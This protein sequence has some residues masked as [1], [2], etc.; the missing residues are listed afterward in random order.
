MS[1]DD[2]GPEAVP[3]LLDMS[4]FP[5]LADRLQQGFLDFI[6]L[7]RLMGNPDGLTDDPAFEFGGD[8]ALATDKGALL[9]RQ[10]PGRD[11]RRRP[12]RGRAR[13]HPHGA[14]RARDELLDAAHPQHRLR[15]LRADP[16]PAL[17]GRGGAAA[18]ALADPVDVGPG[19]A[20]RL[21]QPHDH[22][23]AAEHARAQG[24]DRDGLRRSP[25]RQRPDRGRGA[26]DRGAAAQ[27]GARLLPPAGRLRPALLRD[28]ARSATSRGPAADGSGYFVWDIGPKR[29][30]STVDSRHRPAADHQHAR[31]TTASASTRT[32]R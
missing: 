21:R 10:Q 30:E 20:R 24:P 4:N 31:R 8:S 26:D 29:T 23:S 5:P 22:R 3:A 12:D 27:A 2:V 25:G 19:R 7:G 18:A 32:T 9:L 14:L 17:P 16:L 13:H 15:G 6:Y 28:P 1:E 11:R